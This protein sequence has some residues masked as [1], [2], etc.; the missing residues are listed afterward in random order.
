M[1]VLSIAKKQMEHI[2]TLEIDESI[3]RSVR[4]V[5]TPV[6]K[7]ERFFPTRSVSFLRL[8]YRQRHLAA[9]TKVVH[10]LSRKDW[11]TRRFNIETVAQ[12][13][14]TEVIDGG[15]RQRFRKA[16]LVSCG[17][18]EF[19]G[20]K[21]VPLEFSETDN[22]VDKRSQAL[23]DRS[24]AGIVLTTPTDAGM[25]E[26][27]MSALELVKVVVTPGDYLRNGTLSSSTFLFACN[28]YIHPTDDSL[29]HRM[30][31]FLL[32]GHSAWGVDVPK[33]NWGNRKPS[34]QV[35][36][37]QSRR[38]LN[39]KIEEL[40]KTCNTFIQKW[41]YST[42]YQMIGELYNTCI[43]WGEQLENGKWP[44]AT[45]LAQSQQ[46]DEDRNLLKILVLNLKYKNF[47][48]LALEKINVWNN[49]P[50][51][52]ST[53]WNRNLINNLLIALKKMKTTLR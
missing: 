40:R 53:M 48:S 19:K 18:Q 46:Q 1:D 7:I 4:I 11:T 22:A 49:T 39:L 20:K 50:Q 30:A 25:A 36:F 47:L 8:F 14:D 52:P 41:P 42:D 26:P 28:N 10:H 38:R 3:E 5:R 12:V 44:S 37:I 15:L 34:L 27:I 6:S 33:K 45:T 23:L 2:Y 35:Q 24:S 51:F 43:G 29:R 32:P 16:L 17:E 9:I 13:T 21:L 31:R